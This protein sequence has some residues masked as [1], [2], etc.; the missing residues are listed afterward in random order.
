[1]R[2]DIYMVYGILSG[3]AVGLVI[4]IRIMLDF[5]AD[6]RRAMRK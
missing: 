4:G 5:M 1:M 2:V 6:Y 3:G